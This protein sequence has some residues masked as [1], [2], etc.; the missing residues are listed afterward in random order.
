MFME[1]STK[2][3]FKKFI[4]KQLRRVLG[5]DNNMQIRLLLTMALYKSHNNKDLIVDAA[6]VYTS[7]SLIGIEHF[8]IYLQLI[9]IKIKE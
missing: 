3:Y 9:K 5:Y 6:T 7:A 8:E 1:T 4:F 2:I